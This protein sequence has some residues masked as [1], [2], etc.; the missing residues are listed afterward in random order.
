MLF[1]VPTLLNGCL[2]AFASLFCSKFKKGAAKGVSVSDGAIPF[3]PFGT[4]SAASDFPAQNNI[5][6]RICVYNC[7]KFFC[8]G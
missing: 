1:V 8:Y 2:R 6:L 4:Y 5:S 3:T 7:D